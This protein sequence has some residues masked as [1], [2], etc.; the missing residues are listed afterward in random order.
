MKLVDEVLE[1]C[2][3]ELKNEK[4]RVKVEEEILS[5]AIEFIL[6]KIKPYV[7][8][9]CIFLIIIILLILFIL[10]LILSIR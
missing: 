2:I 8:G 4:N 7:I 10:Y 3:N 6:E 5:P 9:T 1:I